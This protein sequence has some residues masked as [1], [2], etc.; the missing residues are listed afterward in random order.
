MIS[1]RSRGTAVRTRKDGR[2]SRARCNRSMKSVGR[3]SCGP[4]TERSGRKYRPDVGR[5]SVNLRYRIQDASRSFTLR[6]ATPGGSM[7]ELN[8]REFYKLR[9]VIPRIYFAQARFGT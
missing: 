4:R 5:V 3:P 2:S 1:V 7:Q 9:C 6:V 8:I